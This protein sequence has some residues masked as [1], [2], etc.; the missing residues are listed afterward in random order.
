MGD[1]L[2]PLVADG[3]GGICTQVVLESQQTGILQGL[4]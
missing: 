4:E 2:I 3:G 1:E